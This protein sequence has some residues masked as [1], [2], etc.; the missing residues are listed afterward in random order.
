MQLNSVGKKQQQ[1]NGSELLYSL[2]LA[3]TFLETKNVGV[4]IRPGIL[5]NKPETKCSRLNIVC[6]KGQ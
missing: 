4:G 5:K 1:Q 6:G 2:L 3:L